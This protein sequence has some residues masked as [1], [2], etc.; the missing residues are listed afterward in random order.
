MDILNFVFYWVG[1]ITTV[2]LLALAFLWS[3]G[4]VGIDKMT[5]EEY[6]AEIKAR[7]N[8]SDK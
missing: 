3:I 1:V 6:V 5:E 7:K 2:L 8:E 4:K